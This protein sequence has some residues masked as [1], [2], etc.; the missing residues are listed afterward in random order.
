MNTI[1]PKLGPLIWKTVVLHTVTYFVFG[2]I[3]FFAF[4]YATLLAEPGD[5]GVRPLD[6]PLVMAGPLFQPLRAVFFALVFYPLREVLFR[7]PRGWLLIWWTLL[8]LGI[9]NTFGPSPC[10]IEGMIYSPLPFW[11]HI[12]GFLETAIQALVLS[13]SLYFWVHHPN[14]KWLHWM[15]HTVFVVVIGLAVLGVLSTLQR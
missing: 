9:L 5:S 10:S 4:D 1:Q 7:R 6:H 13:G 8:V 15:L 14:S 2:V 3:A 12:V 11:E